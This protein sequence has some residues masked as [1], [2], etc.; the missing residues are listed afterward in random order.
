[1]SSGANLTTEISA[2]LTTTCV[3]K[4]DWIN[5]ERSINAVEIILFIAF[6]LSVIAAIV[7][8]ASIAYFSRRPRYTLQQEEIH[9]TEGTQLTAL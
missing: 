6:I 8:V 5:W 9:V 1:M 7:Y 3:E 4:V 2:V